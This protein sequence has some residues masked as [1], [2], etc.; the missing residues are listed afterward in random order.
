MGQFQI[1]KEVSIL[2]TQSWM[3]T[4]LKKLR[5]IKKNEILSF[6]ITWMELEVTMLSEIS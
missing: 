3:G 4:A 5:Y 6:A 2:A 1:S